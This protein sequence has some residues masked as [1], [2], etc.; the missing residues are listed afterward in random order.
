MWTLATASSAQFQSLVEPLYADTRRMLEALE[1]KEHEGDGNEIEIEQVQAWI[2]L[3]LYQCQKTHYRRAWI[4]AGRAFRLVQLTRLFEVDGADGV[5]AQI[6]HANWVEVE[7]KRRTFW[8]AYLLD[9]FTSMQ[10]DLP[11]TLNEEVV[12]RCFCERA[13]YRVGAKSRTF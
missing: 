5:L 2:L 13:K 8:M 7:E 4:S 12:S 3:V 11:L 9:R 1:S 6:N 10:D